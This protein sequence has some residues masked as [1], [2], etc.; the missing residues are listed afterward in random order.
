MR[1][2]C[3]AVRLPFPFVVLLLKSVVNEMK[4][5]GVLMR[6]VQIDNRQRHEDERL[7][8]HDQDV[9]Y[10]PTQRQQ[11]LRSEQGTLPNE[12]PA[13]APPINAI[14]MK[15]ISPAYMLRTDAVRG[16]SVLAIRFTPSSSK[17]TGMPHLPNGCSVNS[18]TKPPRPFHLYAIEQHQREYSESHAERGV[19]SVEGTTLKNGTPERHHSRYPIDGD[20]VHQVSCRTPR[21]KWSAP[22]E[23]PCC[24]WRRRNAARLCHKLNGPF[25]KI[26]QSA[27]CTADC[28]LGHAAEYQ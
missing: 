7:Q 22:A 3:T 14:R 5:S 25:A 15:I 1:Q 12:K 28:F 2:R 9:E 17:L 19:G 27:R 18:P 26:L 23:Q 16:K 10:C 11:N 20:Q 6:H 8:R 13:H 21:R 24:S 4:I